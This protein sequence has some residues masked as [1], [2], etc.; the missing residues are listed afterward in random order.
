MIYKIIDQTSAVIENGGT[1]RFKDT[2][3]DLNNSINLFIISTEQ[4]YDISASIKTYDDIALY[5]YA[6][7]L[8][9]YAA[10]FSGTS[11][12]DVAVYWNGVSF[13]MSLND[14]ADQIAQNFATSA[15]E[16]YDNVIVTNNIVTF[17]QKPN[18]V[19]FLNEDYTEGTF[20]VTYDITV[21]SS[22]EGL[23]KKTNININDIQYFTQSQ[24]HIYRIGL[25][26]SPMSDHG[27]MI[28]DFMYRH[29]C[30][31]S[32]SISDYEHTVD[33]IGDAICQNE[34]YAVILQNFK[35]SITNEYY[36]AFAKSDYLEET[37]DAI[38]LNDKRKEYI[39]Q[40]FEL[41]GFIGSYRSLIAAIEY[42]GYG[43]LLELK[44]IWKSKYDNSFKH[45]PINNV[46]LPY[47]DKALAGY[48]KTS[49]SVLVYQI[50]T[51]KST[52]PQFDSDGF[53]Y[54]VNVLYNTDEILLKLNALKSILERDFMPLNTKIV[55][56]T[57]EFQ[58]I[59]GIDTIIWET[60]ISVYEYNLTKN[61]DVNVVGSFEST[62]IEVMN[63]K[64]FVDAWSLEPDTA[65][66]L[67]FIQ[68]STTAFFTDI[69][70]EVNRIYDQ[71][72][73]DSDYDVLT[74]FMSTDF[75]LINIS[76]SIGEPGY[77]A[78]LSFY[79]Y[80]SVIYNESGSEV[81]V[82]KRRHISELT[83]GIKL[84][85]RQLG[86]Y[87]VNVFLF[88]H[89]G[90]SVIVGIDEQIVVRNK[91][92]DFK[93]F[94]TVGT[95]LTYEK[96]LALQSTYETDLTITS[97]SDT[98]QIDPIDEG[99][100][101][102]LPS[103]NLSWNIFTGVDHIMSVQHI[104][105][106]YYEG[107][108]TNKSTR[109]SVSNLNGVPIEEMKSVSISSLGYVYSTWL[110]DLI[111]DGSAGRRSISLKQFSGH[112]FNTVSQ[113]FDGSNR[114]DFLQ[115]FVTELNQTTGI[116][117]NFTYS[118][119]HY[120]VDDL[121]TDIRPMVRM[122][123]KDLSFMSRLLI[124]DVLNT[125]NPVFDNCY[126]VDEIESVIPYH[127]GFELTLNTAIP[128]SASTLTVTYDSQTFTIS[129]R[130]LDRSDM[131]NKLRTSIESSTFPIH[132]F[133]DGSGTVFIT[134][135]KQF[136]IHHLQ[137]GL[138]AD[139]PRG[140]SSSE[141]FKTSPGSELIRCETVYAM[142][143]EDSKINNRDVRWTLSDSLTNEILDTQ[144]SY[145]FRTV[146]RDKRSYSIKL[147]TSDKFGN[148]VRSKAGCVMIS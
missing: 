73:I 59:L 48:S 74:K 61:I 85:I 54:Y 124:I 56:I 80:S 120:S 86:T 81:F 132:V 93:L 67:K 33:V 2:S 15:A 100:A 113:I 14:T 53:E 140:V 105:S 97:N 39:I 129:Q 145:V 118:I 62:D 37:E 111:G 51:P 7:G 29:T 103:P 8:E 83:N 17:N 46:V 128:A 5:T 47:I 143:D 136:S 4:L 36:T 131:V 31:L 21:T 107:D 30:Q 75:G 16:Q 10:T 40:L 49:Q 91:F 52:D 121:G 146:L 71:T 127:A 101:H 18:G 109:R 87:S 89:Y 141:L 122:T 108:I 58:S 130:F 65:N 147:E 23:T 82:S 112:Q 142:I 35:Q 104:V 9:S 133:D 44:E 38:L 64:C 79:E 138:N 1:L 66:N 50:N 96:D 6:N 102:V 125:F 99:F 72:T 110:I 84:G 78:S 69:Y 95:G 57:G 117:E 90:G 63:H 19:T 70:F 20:G 11:T 45:T 43:D 123:A 34:R 88:D 126:S 3:V 148:N 92:T 144:N 98:V 12:D 28:D 137:L 119:N 24:F 60:M 26:F 41:T 68:G 32:I 77:D 139:I 22:I 55:D 106:K 135:N 42:F 134:S 115:S 76:L 13:Q 27:T 116:F 94:R 114:L 25:I